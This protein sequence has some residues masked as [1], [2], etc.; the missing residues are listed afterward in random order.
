[1]KLRHF[2]LRDLFWLCLVVGLAFGLGI[3]NRRLRRE[4]AKLSAEKQAAQTA[5]AQAQYTAA[6]AAASAATR[7]RELGAANSFLEDDVQYF[8]PGPE[9]KSDPATG[10]ENAVTAEFRT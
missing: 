6:V 8:S 3:D 1:M 9:T 5:T 4:N 10:A 2:S 7:Q